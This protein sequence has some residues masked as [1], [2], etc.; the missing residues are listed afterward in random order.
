MA[1]GQEKD[2]TVEISLTPS[3]NSNGVGPPSYAM[4]VEDPLDEMM[5]EGA[6]VIANNIGAPIVQLSPPLSN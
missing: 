1:A 5:A 3:F 6:V 2:E 4:V